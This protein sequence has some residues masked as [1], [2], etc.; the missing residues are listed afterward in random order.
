MSKA[1]AV[2]GSGFGDEGKGLMTD[3]LTTGMSTSDSVVI[4]YNGSAQ[5]GHCQTADTLIFAANGMRYLGDMVGDNTN[6]DSSFP[7]SKQQRCGIHIVV[8]Y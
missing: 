3:F 8:V 4:R 2:I 6:S 7:L 1:Y 5:A